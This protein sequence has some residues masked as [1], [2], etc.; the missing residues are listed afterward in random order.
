VR[1]LRKIVVS[2][3]LVWAGIVVGGAQ[4]GSAGAAVVGPADITAGPDGAMWF[5]E[6]DANR[7]GRITPAGQVRE[8]PTG[9][10]SGPLAITAGP[11]GNVWFTEYG[12]CFEGC[13]GGDRIGRATPQGVITVFPVTR[14][15]T[16]RGTFLV[17]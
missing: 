13:V 1:C 8:F 3:A 17:V 4:A 2:V 7:I 10:N 12:N 6:P 9:K 5:T 14:P 15:A 16:A 11:D